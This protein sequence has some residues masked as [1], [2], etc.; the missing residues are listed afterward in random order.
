[1]WFNADTTAHGNGPRY[2]ILEPRWNLDCL[3]T[4][5]TDTNPIE[6][7]RN[8]KCLVM[9]PPPRLERGTSRST[10]FDYCQLM[11]LNEFS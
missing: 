8:I 7:T 4:E 9:V 3:R 5:A 1:M 10:I 11:V 6:I 2:R